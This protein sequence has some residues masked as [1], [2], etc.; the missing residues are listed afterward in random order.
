MNEGFGQLLGIG[1]DMSSEPYQIIAD[2]VNVPENF[3]FMSYCSR[4]QGGR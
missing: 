4:R 3:D 2:G 1:L